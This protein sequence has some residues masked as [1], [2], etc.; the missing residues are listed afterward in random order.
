MLESNSPAFLL[1]RMLS[2]FPSPPVP[3]SLHNHSCSCR[4]WNSCK[5]AQ[6]E[7]F[8][9]QSCL[10]AWPGAT[11]GIACSGAA[12]MRRWGDSEVPFSVVVTA[13][14]SSYVHWNVALR[15]SRIWRTLLS[16]FCRTTEGCRQSE[17][18]VMI[19]PCRPFDGYSMQGFEHTFTGHSPK[20]DSFKMNQNLLYGIHPALLGCSKQACRGS[21][22]LLESLGRETLPVGHSCLGWDEW[23]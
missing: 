8:P 4:E 3:Q 20:W 12:E 21:R 1:P 18:Q 13:H 23:L 15:P 16:L 5:I 11:L 9:F 17:D 7:K 6:E 19:T 14:D 10:V 2:P 22:L